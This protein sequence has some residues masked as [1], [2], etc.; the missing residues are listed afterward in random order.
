MLI[1][2][3]KQIIWFEWH[4]LQSLGYNTQLGCLASCLC[5]S[6]N[7][8]VKSRQIRLP[9]LI[10]VHVCITIIMLKTDCDKMWD[11]C[12]AIWGYA[13]IKTADLLW[14]TVISACGI[15]TF[16][17]FQWGNQCMYFIFDLPSNCV[18]L[19]LHFLKESWI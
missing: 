16:L 4:N 14:V 18:T 8:N 10:C 19:C 2:K 11:K 3:K 6:T 5:Y 1:K 9:T 13:N 17:V 15:M 12:Y 7:D